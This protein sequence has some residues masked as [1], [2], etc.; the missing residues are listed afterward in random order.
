[1]EYWEHFERVSQAALA[2]LLFNTHQKELF[3]K[4]NKCHERLFFDLVTRLIKPTHF[5]EIGAHE[6]GTALKVARR[7][8]DTACIAF[9][10]DRDVYAHF[11]AVHAA[12][13]PPPNFQY[14]YRAISDHDGVLAFQKQLVIEGG[15]A[16]I[17]AKNNSV[18]QKSLGILYESVMT[19]CQSMDSF[20]KTLP[21]SVD[22]SVLRLDV[23][24]LCYEVL[25]GSQKLLDSCTAIYAEVEDFTIWKDQK[26]V[27]AVHEI[28]AHKGFIPVSRDVETVG[29]YNVL[30]LKYDSALIRSFRSR[31]AIY[32]AELQH[33]AEMSRNR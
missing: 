17:L 12:G 16:D 9:E 2:P 25:I 26:T 6:A 30:W 27:F 24:G 23:E 19:P 20:V 15:Q 4:T 10:A 29:Q 18:K 22:R 11:L 8:E 14:L 33:I 31:L 1:M 13:S 21:M 7:L 3:A 32:F 28:L 5:F